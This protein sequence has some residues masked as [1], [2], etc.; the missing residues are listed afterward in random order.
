MMFHRVKVSFIF[1]LWE[2]LENCKSLEKK[3]WVIELEAAQKFKTLTLW[4]IARFYAFA[5]RDGNNR[6]YTV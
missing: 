4:L 5:S 3:R 2:T 6:D 1:D